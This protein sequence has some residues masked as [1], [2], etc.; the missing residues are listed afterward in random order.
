[1]GRFASRVGRGRAHKQARL[2][3]LVMLSMLRLRAIAS[4][5]EF[6]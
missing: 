4:N 5:L 6:K 3:L 2:F 1:M